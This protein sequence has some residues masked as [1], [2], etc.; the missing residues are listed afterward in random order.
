[1]CICFV[2]IQKFIHIFKI[3]CTWN[4]IFSFIDKKI[5]N[6]CL[7]VLLFLFTIIFVSK[8]VNGRTMSSLATQ[9]LF[10]KWSSNA[11]NLLELRKQTVRFIKIMMVTKLNFPLNKRVSSEVDIHELFEDLYILMHTLL[12]NLL[13][14]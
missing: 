4:A 9:R 10:L 7:L 3:F 8:N 13:N 12:D 11:N 6:V 1:M 5:F 14:N 2:S